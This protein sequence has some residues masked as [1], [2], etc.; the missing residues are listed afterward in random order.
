VRAIAHLLVPSLE[1]LSAFPVTAAVV[2]W[3]SGVINGTFSLLIRIDRAGGF[4]ECWFVSLLDGISSGGS[5]CGE[6]IPGCLF[7]GLGFGPTF[8]GIVKR[9]QGFLRNRCKA[10]C[11]VLCLSPL[12]GSVVISYGEQLFLGGLLFPFF[13]VF[14]F[15]AGIMSRLLTGCFSFHKAVPVSSQSLC[16]FFSYIFVSPFWFSSSE[17]PVTKFNQWRLLDLSKSG[18]Y[19][20]CCLYTSQPQFGSYLR[21]RRLLP[22]LF[23]EFIPSFSNRTPCYPLPVWSFSTVVFTLFIRPGCLPA[24]ADRDFPSCFP[25]TLPAS[26]HGFS[27]PKEQNILP[28]VA[29]F[30]FSNTSSL[31]FFRQDVSEFLPGN[32]SFSTR[33]W[34]F[35]QQTRSLLRLG[36][37]HLRMMMLRG[38]SCP[39]RKSSAFQFPQR[40]PLPHA[41]RS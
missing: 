11:D 36:R 25:S 6:R 3:L 32:V 15:N 41:L 14:P 10:N 9:F 4:D 29:S 38:V 23:A 30:G 17:T 16:T 5:L 40:T 2:A 8:P 24:S 22:H 26:G 27:S 19:L 31:R 21:L 7:R 13:V 12:L 37:W 33:L 39:L 34:T 28:G 18:H 35:F 1:L 20:T